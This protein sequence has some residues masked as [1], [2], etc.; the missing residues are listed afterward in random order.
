MN[1]L[2]INHY[3]SSVQHGKASRQYYLAKELIK[4]GHNVTIAASSFSHL[5]FN[6]PELTGDM[7]IEEIDGI[8]FIWLRTNEYSTN[9]LSRIK[10]MFS[11]VFS[12]FKF[13][14]EIMKQSAADIV[15]DCSTYLLTFYASLSI[16]K[17][18]NTKVIVEIRDIWPE[19]LININNYSRLNPFIALLQ[20]TENYIYKKADKIVCSLAGA[21]EH[22]LEHG[23]NEEK[24][25]YIPNGFEP[26]DS[27]SIENSQLPKEH[28]ELLKKLKVDYKFIFGYTGTHGHA[29]SLDI[30]MEGVSKLKSKKACALFVG[31]GN[32]KE[33]FINFAKANNINNVYFLP[34][35]EKKLVPL[36]LE[37]IDIGLVGGRARD[38]HKYGV[39]PNKVLDY[40]FAKVPV[41]LAL[42]T[43]YSPVHLANAGIAVDPSDKNE[44]FLA[45]ENLIDSKN[46]LSDMGE[47]GN[48]FILKEHS[49]CILAKKYIDLINKIKGVK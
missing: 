10:N 37:Y 49:Y 29:N 20:F 34:P 42:K 15:I 26:Y 12:L 31:T 48:S 47:R 2:F 3:A 46:D 13:K 22:M 24:F 27:K 30:F 35:V 39:S 6:Q 18:L 9:G 5:R 1:I 14:S 33:K 40:M 38:I 32:A 17:A 11:F 7:T 25:E 16:A 19:S 43:K 4:Q 44:I 23:M 45:M 21:K 36:I 28:E 41:L 8:K